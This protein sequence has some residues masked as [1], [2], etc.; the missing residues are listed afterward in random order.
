MKV[1]VNKDGEIKYPC[2]MIADDTGHIYLMANK[3]KGTRVYSSN[4]SADVGDH[5]ERWVSDDFKPFHG[6]ITLEN[7]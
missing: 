7:D 3:D 2:L 1:T 4:D 6:S 5:N